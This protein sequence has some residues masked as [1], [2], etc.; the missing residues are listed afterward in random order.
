MVAFSGADDGIVAR[1][2]GGQLGD[3]AEAH[4][5]M[6]A[7]GDQRRPRGR[8]QRGGVK[9]R[10]AQS[11]LGDAIHRRR[12]DDAAEGARY[13]VALVVGHVGFIRVLWYSF[14]EL[15]GRTLRKAKM[16]HASVVGLPLRS[17]V[18]VFMDGQKPRGRMRGGCEDGLNQLAVVDRLAE[19]SN[20]GAATLSIRAR[21][22]H[23][24]GYPHA[25]L[26][27][28]GSASRCLQWSAQKTRARSLLA[29]RDRRGRGWRA[30]S[31]DAERYVSF[32]NRECY[33]EGFRKRAVV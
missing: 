8:A 25:C 13:A 32:S 1:E 31:R 9:L 11:R 28:R 20:R 17:K 16:R 5:V 19:V 6:V 14:G 27:A 3:H 26:P 22:K 30:G 12:R 7:A 10:V 24:A 23:T 29:Q 18:V 4:R 33:Y 2:T 15:G 21:G